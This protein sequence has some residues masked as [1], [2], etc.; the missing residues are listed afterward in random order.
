MPGSG[1]RVLHPA[2][3]D[4]LPDGTFVLDGG[5]P[6]LVLDDRLLSWTPAGYV[7]AA[8]PTAARRHELITPPSLVALLERERLPLVPLLHPSAEMAQTR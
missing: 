7:E 4:E 5:E 1:Q 6:W 2:S 8:A 3:L